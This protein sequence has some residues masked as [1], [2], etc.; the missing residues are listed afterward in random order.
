MKN[1]TASVPGGFNVSTS[2]GH[3][4]SGLPKR[5]RYEIAA[6]VHSLFL[7]GALIVSATNGTPLT[8]TGGAEF[9]VMVSSATTP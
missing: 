8:L 7:D 9:G 5:I 4:P 2:V 3:S 1:A 6:G